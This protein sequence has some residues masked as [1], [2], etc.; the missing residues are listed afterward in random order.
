[1]FADQMLDASALIGVKML[2]FLIVG[3]GYYSFKEN[4]MLS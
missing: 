2:D 3:D 1:M 4:Q